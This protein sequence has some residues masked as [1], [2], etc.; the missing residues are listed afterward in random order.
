MKLVAGCHCDKLCCD[1]IFFNRFPALGY[2]SPCTRVGTEGKLPI[3]E[4]TV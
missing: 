1:G 4:G 3:G 2:M